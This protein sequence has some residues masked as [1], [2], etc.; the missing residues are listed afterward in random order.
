MLYILTLQ[1]ME[2]ITQRKWTSELQGTL[3]SDSRALLEG[4][5]RI[6]DEIQKNVDA[7]ISSCRAL[8]WGFRV[9]IFVKTEAGRRLYPSEIRY[10]F[11]QKKFP[12]ERSISRPMEM[13]HWA[14]ENLTIMDEGIELSLT[15]QIPRNAWLSNGILI[16]YILVFTFVLYRAYASSAREARQ[17]E[18]ANQQALEA[19]NERLMAAQQRLEDVSEKEAGYQ[20]EI[21]TLKSDLD[22]ASN[23][24]RETEDEALSEME[25]L[26]ERLQESVGLKEEL[27]LEVLRLAEELER[28]QS[29][30]Q[31][32]FKKRRKKTDSA[33]KRFKTLYKNLE[34]QERAIEGFLDLEVDL[35]LRAEELIHT[36]NDDSTKLTVKRKLFS[37]KGAAPTFECEFGYKGRIY[38][39]PGPGTRTQILAIGTKNTQVK[40][41]AF[42][43]NK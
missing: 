6:E 35:Q 26:E 1:A 33:A 34:I 42:L 12:Q 27:E 8:R 29:A 38:W 43:E 2:G 5:M 9:K 11:D 17:F 15:V 19:A 13:M 30:Q 20:D 21:A 7:F 4:R 28:I 16:F 41:L 31:R 32:P 10:A 23:Q 18:L 24:V 40:D 36:M 25:A 37:K 14:E 3:I 22:L 39:R